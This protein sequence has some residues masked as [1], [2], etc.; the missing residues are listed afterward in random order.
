MNLFEEWYVYLHRK[1]TDMKLF[2]IGI[3][4]AK[5]YQK[6]YKSTHNRNTHWKRTVAKHGGF[7]HEKV[8][9]G[10]TMSDACELEAF[11]ISEYGLENLT[12]ITPGGEGVK[13]KQSNEAR[14]KMRI[15]HT[16]VPL[17]HHH[18]EA[19]RKS[20]KYGGEHWYSKSVIDNITGVTYGSAKEAAV[21]IGMK[22]T[23]LYNQLTGKNKSKTSLTFK[24]Q[25]I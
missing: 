8:A 5:K 22:Y 12:N 11:L 18:A 15:S 20:R 14:E 13:V 21:A 9:E 2:Y 3:G 24:K 10:L 4:K 16:G 19:I 25:T 17:Q 1:P 7:N 6:R 23:T